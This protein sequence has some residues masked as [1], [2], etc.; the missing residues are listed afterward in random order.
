MHT[1]P[2]TPV[3]LHFENVMLAHQTYANEEQHILIY[4]R[5]ETKVWIMDMYDVPPMLH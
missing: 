2:P 5:D 3:S 4:R 1:P